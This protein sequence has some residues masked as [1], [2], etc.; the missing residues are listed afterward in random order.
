MVR[1]DGYV[2]VLDFGLARLRAD[3]AGAGPAKTEADTD[4]GMLVGT[5][6]YM[7]PEQARAEAAD[8]P[9]DVF[10]LGIIL[11][12]L[13]TD[14]HPFPAATEFDRLHAITSLPPVAPASR[15][16][17]VSPA[18][19]ALILHMLEKAPGLRPTAAEVTAALN[20]LTAARDRPTLAAPPAARRV[21]GRE[22][23]R[24]A[25][26]AAFEDAAAGRG[27]LICVTG[28]PG[29]GKT[30]L[31]E[32]FLR[33]LTDRGRP[34]CTARG[35]CSERLAGAEAYL[36]VFEALDDLLR[37]NSGEVA[38]RAL[39][40]VAPAWHG[41]VVSQ[42]AAA[43]QES[44]PRTAQARVCGLHPRGIPPAA[45]RA[46]LRRRPLG[47]RVDRGPDRLPRRA[48]RRAPRSRRAHL[49]PD[50]DVAR[51]SSVYGRPARTPAARRR[52]GGA[53]RHARPGGGGSVSEIGVSRGISFRTNLA[54]W[55]MPGPRATRCSSSTWSATS[56]TGA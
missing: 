26:W 47:R 9:A 20:A 35:R 55:S 29:I 52:R 4:P 41:Q 28:E 18:L 15:N 34:H 31:V 45:A 16:P 30:T 44:V 39:A 6:C 42:A 51:S 43:P 48:V 17:A 54:P 5:A 36:P 19:D 23:E 40:A 49:P 27:R 12:E 56:A 8:G 7:A 46:V 11:Y 33:D 10:A 14:R 1:P 50:G 53:A 3:A 24:G 32:D 2:K 13:V 38:A 25:L 22:V 21:V 37:G